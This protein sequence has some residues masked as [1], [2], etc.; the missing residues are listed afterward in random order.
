MLVV[1]LLLAIA[2][3]AL[4]VGS[5]LTF[6]QKRIDRAVA[7]LEWQTS[8]CEAPSPDDSFH[9]NLE[10]GHW[11][12][13]R[14]QATQ[15]FGDAWDIDHWAET[16]EAPAAEQEPTM[17]ATQWDKEREKERPQ[18]QVKRPKY[19]KPAG[20]PEEILPLSRAEK[21]RIKRG[22]GAIAALSRTNPTPEQM[23]AVRANLHRM[24][25]HRRQR[26][27]Q[28]EIQKTIDIENFQKKKAEV[29]EKIIGPHPLKFTVGAMGTR[30]PEGE[31]KPI[32]VTVAKD[33]PVIATATATK[34]RPVTV[35][36]GHTKWLI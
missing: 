12:W 32:N 21:R 8:L 24:S 34:D 6:R 5:V 33:H 15:W 3:S 19:R 27:Q 1:A 7:E 22:K 29:R 13:H 10:I 16:Q 17:S 25:E 23:A 4:L 31:H 9:C 18:R 20:Q 36:K 11:G 14:N 30:R 35:A 26:I 28:A 2:G